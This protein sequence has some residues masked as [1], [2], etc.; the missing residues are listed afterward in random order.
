MFKSIRKGGRIAAVTI[1]IVAALT[2]LAAPAALADGLPTPELEKSL[3]VDVEGEDPS[4]WFTDDGNYAIIADYDFDD[5][6]NDDANDVC[7]GYSRLDLKSGEVTPIDIP[8]S[9]LSDV[10]STS[11]GELLYWLEDGKVIVYSVEDQQRIAHPIQV[12][13]GRIE[14][15]EDGNSLTA[16]CSNGKYGEVSVFNLQSNKKT[17]TYKFEKDDLNAVLS[18]NGK[19]LYVCSN[20]KLKIIDIPDGSTSIKEIPGNAQCDG[21]T[22]ADGSDKLLLIET[23]SDD[24]DSLYTTYFMADYDGNNIDKVADGHKIH[25]YGWGNSILALTG[26]NF[27][28]IVIDSHSGKQ[29]RYVIRNDDEDSYDSIS[30]ISRNGDIA[31]ARVSHDNSSAIRLIDTKT[32]QRVD[33]KI[34]SDSTGIP[35]FVDNDQ[36]I[37]VDYSDAEDPTKMHID[38]YKSNIHYSPIEKLIFFAQDNMPIV[39]GGGIAAVLMIIGGIAVVCVRR[40]KRAAAQTSIAGTAPKAKKHKR[41]RHKKYA[42]QGQVAQ[43][44]SA[45]STFD[46]QWQ[47]SGEPLT[48]MPQQPVASSASKFCRHC[49]TPLVPEA[50]FCPKCGHPVE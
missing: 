19:R 1:G 26:E 8:K 5:N 30:D 13:N 39:V 45:G 9:C 42:Q 43:Q 48:V 11:N 16:Y 33:C 22:T 35:E 38:V 20:R 50:K 18:R 27:D 17:F 47:S 46:T 24:D 49:G 23:T 12:K 40:K 34:K 41:S 6:Y 32:G 25:I 28:T 29:I 31:L 10:C 15:S 2:P 44:P 7:Y 36:K 3:T 14:L 37:V 21:V 4:A